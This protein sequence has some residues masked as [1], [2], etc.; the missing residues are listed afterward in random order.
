M[1]LAGTCSFRPEA[2]I[3]LERSS[4]AKTLEGG[5]NHMLALHGELFDHSPQSL[6]TGLA[7]EGPAF[8]R[9]LNGVFALAYWDGESL[10][11]ARDHLGAKPLFYAMHGNT[12][13]FG[14]RPANVFAQGFA[15]AIDHSSLRELFALGPA[16]TPG[17][18]VFRGLRE[19]L[20]GELVQFTRAGLHRSFYWQLQSRPHTDSH[21]ETVET[22]TTLVRESTQRQLGGKLCAFLSGGLDSSLVTAIAA[23][24]Y[25]ERGKRL[26]TF[27]FDFEG[28]DEHYQQNA[29][30][31]GRDTPFAREMAACL[32]TDHHELT[33]TSADLADFL[34][35]AAV[36]RGLPGMGD[37]DASL[38]Y[39]CSV[40]GREFN[41]ALTG[42][43]ADEIFGGYPWFRSEAAFRQR[44]FPWSNMPARRSFLRDDLLDTL[45]L[46]AYAQQAYEASV[47]Q[48]PRCPAD[49][50]AEARRR[51]ITWLNL[52]WFMQ[53]LLDRMDRM[54][55]A[56][57]CRAP[58][59]DRRLLEYAWNIPW[60]LKCKDGHV[61]YLLRM[62]GRGLLPEPVLW[63][64]KSPFPKT[65]N[66]AYEHLLAA[67]MRDILA[68]PSEPVNALID[69]K[70][71]EAFLSAPADYGAPWYGQLMA[72]PQRIAYFLQLNAWMRA[73]NLSL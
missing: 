8:L 28:N 13:R 59:A 9:Q 30:Q 47:A 39:F 15:P 21:D 68:S 67:R 35:A 52:R 69:R 4:A 43:C 57:C 61:K 33:C 16:K 71:A 72:A 1:H 41:A 45:D 20:P 31:P 53:T 42:E 18:G 32:G 73:H 70:K 6:L 25:K 66:P 51:E 58:L 50:P 64:E 56:L 17:C 46:E 38:L 37:V 22:V 19:V 3:Q 11:L 40:V 44:T 63:R 23:E 55:G 49:S 5:R 60:E 48:T 12:L 54:S 65:Y 62:A 29:F 14:S 2:Y 26:T 36:A 24:K 7:R 10:H 27:S 34:D